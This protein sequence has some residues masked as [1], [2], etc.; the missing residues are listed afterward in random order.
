MAE[1]V[2]PKKFTTKNSTSSFWS[3]FAKQTI[4]FQHALGELVDNALSATLAKPTGTGKQTATIEITLSENQDSSVTVQVADAGV[5][6]GL[7]QLATDD[8]NIFNLG[9]MPPERG[10]MNEHGFG[11]KMHWR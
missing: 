6:I 1:A 2:S 8:N 7:N 9:Y 10:F 5:G 11:L 4:D 3:G